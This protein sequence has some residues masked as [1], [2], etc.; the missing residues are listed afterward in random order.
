[1]IKFY[2]YKK[3]GTS[4]KGEATLTRLKKEYKFVDVTENPPGAAALKKMIKQSGEELKKFFNTSGVAYKELNMKE[5]VKTMKD[6]DIIALLSS[7][8]KLLKRPIVTDGENTTVGFSED[9]FTRTW[10]KA[11]K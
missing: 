4:R 9:S 11:G 3:C 6:A 7:N 1:M 2:G 10:K 5:K 8:G